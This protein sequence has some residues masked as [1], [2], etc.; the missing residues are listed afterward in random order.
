MFIMTEKQ[1][2]EENTVANNVYK[3]LLIQAFRKVF[4][5]L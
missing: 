2:R 4:V 3:T 5:Y 1:Q